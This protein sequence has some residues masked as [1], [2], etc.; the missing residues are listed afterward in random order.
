[1]LSLGCCMKFFLMCHGQIMTI[2]K[3]LGLIGS[4]N[5][6]STD[7]VP[8]Q[9]NDLSLRHPIAGQALNLFSTPIQSVDVI[10]IQLSTNPN[11]NQQPG[12]NIKKGRCNNHKGGKN[13]NK[14]KDDSNNDR[15]NNNVGEGK[16]EKQKVKFPCKI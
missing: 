14:S 4:V 12:G 10:S 13:N 5:S 11:G 1:M 6:K 3:I 2:D 7:L 9:L 16:K 8:N 15:L